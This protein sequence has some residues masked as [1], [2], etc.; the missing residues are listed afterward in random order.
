MQTIHAFAERLLQRFPLEAGVTP[1]F[2]ILDD[3]MARTLRREAIDAVLGLAA[4]DRKSELGK[5]LEA[6]IAYA[7]DDR[8]DDILADALNYRGWLDAAARYETE[9]HEGLHAVEVLYR[10]HFGVREG[11]TREAIAKEIASLL[12]D[13]ELERV[14]EVLA[15][16]S[17]NDKKLADCVAAARRAATPVARAEELCGVFLKSDGEPRAKFLTNALKDEHPD[18]EPLLQRA[19]DRFRHA[20]GRVEGR[21]LR[22]VRRWP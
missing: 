18:I 8:F 6:A 2:A 12:S 15:G 1:G 13:R 7:A 21:R 4:R 20:L 14:R 19:Q 3:E 9:T 11:A 17:A 22:R 16:G 10:R 5:A